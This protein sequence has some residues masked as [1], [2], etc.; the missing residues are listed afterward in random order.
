[1]CRGL[2]VDATAVETAAASPVLAAESLSDEVHLVS[3][4]ALG[5]CPG[6]HAH[7]F[8][9]SRV[10]GHLELHIAMQ[11]VICE[12]PRIKRCVYDAAR[13]HDKG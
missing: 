11:G 8:A 7:R 1:M 9:H 3:R 2:P 4:R 5:V 12:E 13:V 6:L 10:G